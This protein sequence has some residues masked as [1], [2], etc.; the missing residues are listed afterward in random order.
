MGKQT[1]RIESEDF[2]EEQVESGLADCLHKRWWY[3]SNIVDSPH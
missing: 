3:R 1:T 2:E